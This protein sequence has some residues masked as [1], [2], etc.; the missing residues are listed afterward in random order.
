LPNHEHGF[1]DGRKAGALVKADGVE[2][3]SLDGP[4]QTFRPAFLG[5]RETEI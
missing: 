3:F 4:K 2:I 1:A 5:H